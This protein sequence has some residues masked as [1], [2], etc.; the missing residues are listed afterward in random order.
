MLEGLDFGA[1]YRNL[2][3]DLGGQCAREEHPILLKTIQ[4][5]HQSWSTA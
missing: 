5:L 4:E 2:V 1:Q 3:P